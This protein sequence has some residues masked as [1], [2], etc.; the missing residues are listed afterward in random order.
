MSS[1]TMLDVA[2][3]V[4]G[5]DFSTDSNSVTLGLERDARDVTT[6]RSGRYRSRIGGLRDLT[7]DVEGLWQSD[8]SPVDE[9]AF[10]NIG[11]RNMPVTLSPTGVAG[12]TAYMFQ[13]TQ[14]TY[15][16][17]GAV[18]EEAPFS[19]SLQGSE[20]REGA[21]R[22]KVS[23]VDQSISATG[24]FGALQF[25]EPADGQF[26]YA[27]IHV[28][29]AGTSLSI[30]LES[31]SDAGFSDAETRF[32]FPT[33]TATGG[34]WATRV[35]GPLADQAFWRFNVSAVSGTFSVVCAIGVQ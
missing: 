5:H 26:V 2:V 20:G 14:F 22:G 9:T 18:G 16:M 35:A 25:A 32:P 12:D 30:D 1:F 23:A 34:Y 21:V 4:G 31:A 27:V 17:L 10:N 7:C 28:L 8:D 24:A 19:L 15:N 13:G 33:I 29:E 3:L 6:F 11:V